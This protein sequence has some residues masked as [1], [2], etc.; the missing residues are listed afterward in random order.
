MRTV[1]LLLVA[2]LVALSSAAVPASAATRSCGSIGLSP[3]SDEVVGD[4]RATGVG[5]RTA[6][7]VARASRDHGPS[8]R[9]GTIFRF[10]AYRFRCRGRELDTALP[11]V[12][13]RCVRGAAVVRF[14]KT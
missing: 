1:P 10:R 8:G 13:Y 7:R 2:L 11:A 5:C 4:I 9:P 14:V 3:N 12:R 6:R